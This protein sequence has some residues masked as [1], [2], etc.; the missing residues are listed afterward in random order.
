VIRKKYTFAASVEDH[1]APR[2]F[3]L[4]DTS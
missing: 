1:P 2:I 3:V 4:W